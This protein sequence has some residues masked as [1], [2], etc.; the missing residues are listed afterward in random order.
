M[1]RRGDIGGDHRLPF[2]FPA[3]PP[4]KQGIDSTGPSRDRIASLVATYAREEP[5]ALLLAANDRRVI[6][7]IDETARRRRL[8][9]HG[10][11]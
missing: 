8:R 9:R 1:V 7:L 5:S 10:E 6:R 3:P 4:L 11:W 2:P